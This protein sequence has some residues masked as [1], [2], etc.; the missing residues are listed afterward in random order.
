MAPSHR[1]PLLTPLSQSPW[2]EDVSN[3]PTLGS[4]ASAPHKEEC[5]QRWEEFLLQCLTP[6]FVNLEDGWLSHGSE[7][8]SFGSVLLTSF[9]F[10][11]SLSFVKIKY[12]LPRLGFV[13]MTREVGWV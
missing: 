1:A 2:S 7:F 4:R 9:S 13:N 3:T 11:L 12:L 6:H 8:R 5:C 10:S